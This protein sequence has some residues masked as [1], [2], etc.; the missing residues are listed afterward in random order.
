[1]ESSEENVNVA[2]VELV[3]PL[4]PESIVVSGAVASIVQ[5]REAGV[6]AG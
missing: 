1:L 4:G 2:P 6:T 3:V 5:V